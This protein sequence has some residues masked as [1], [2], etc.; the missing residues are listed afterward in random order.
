[1]RILPRP[2]EAGQWHSP[3][4]GGGIFNA[5]TTSNQIPILLS[6]KHFNPRQDLKCSMG[7]A[8]RKPKHRPTCFIHRWRNTSALGASCDRTDS[9]VF[10]PLSTSEQVRIIG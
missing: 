1:M 6:E 7:G 2:C 5:L 3:K 8:G 10:L 9:A 4:P